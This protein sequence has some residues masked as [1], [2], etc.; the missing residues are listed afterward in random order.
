M[1]VLIIRICI[2]KSVNRSFVVINYIGR[3]TYSNYIFGCL[4]KWVCD[5]TILKNLLQITKGILNSF[6]HKDRKLLADFYIQE[7][8]L[9]EP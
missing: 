9:L 1:I 6:L 2:N 4:K 8:G 3:Y 7:I 5:L